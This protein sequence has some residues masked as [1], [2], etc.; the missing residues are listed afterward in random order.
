MGPFRKFKS[1][2]Q[3]AEMSNDSLIS[4]SLKL[5]FLH[6]RLLFRKNTVLYNITDI[7]SVLKE[8]KCV[9]SFNRDP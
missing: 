8:K 1:L 9:V 2:G 7:S 3:T 6:N 5:Y 4:R